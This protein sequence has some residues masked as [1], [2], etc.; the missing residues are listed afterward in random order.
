[1]LQ[2]TTHKLNELNGTHIK[3]CKVLRLY[4]LSE[5][6]VDPESVTNN[7]PTLSQLAE[8]METTPKSLKKWYNMYLHA[9]MRDFNFLEFGNDKIKDHHGVFF[10]PFYAVE[11]ECYQFSEGSERAM[12]EYCQEVAMRV[13]VDAENGEERAMSRTGG[14]NLSQSQIYEEAFLRNFQKNEA[15]ILEL[16]SGLQVSS[17]A[18]RVKKGHKERILCMVVGCEKH[19]QTKCDGCCTI[20]FRLLSSAA[21]KD[22][23]VSLTISIS[24]FV[25]PL[26]RAFNNLVA[27]V[28]SF[29][30]MKK[31]PHIPA[32]A[33]RAMQLPS[34]SSSDTVGERISKADVPDQMPLSLGTLDAGSRVYVEWEGDHRLYKATVKKIYFDRAVPMIRI[35][36]D[37]KKRHILD[38]IPLRMVKSFIRG[39]NPGIHQN[40]AARH[41]PVSQPS[42]SLGNDSIASATSSSK[43]QE[44][45]GAS[46]PKFPDVA[47]IYPGTLPEGK[48]ETKVT[49]PELGSGWHVIVVSRKGGRD[50]RADRYF[51]SPTDQKFRSVKEV[52]RYWEKNPDEFDAIPSAR[53]SKPPPPFENER[54]DEECD[55]ISRVNQLSYST[56]QAPAY[57]QDSIQRDQ[58]LIAMRSI[59]TISPITTEQYGDN[60]QLP[61]INHPDGVGAMG[62]LANAL[63]PS[64][65]CLKPPGGE[66]TA[67]RNGMMSPK[68]VVN[69]YLPTT[70]N[71][72]HFKS[73]F[74]SPSR[75]VQPPLHHQL[76]QSPSMKHFPGM[77]SASAT[78]LQRNRHTT[79]LSGGAEIGSRRP[80]R[81]LKPITRFEEQGGLSSHLAPQSGMQSK[82]ALCHCP[83]CNKGDLS[84]QGIYAHY[85]RAHNGKVLWQKVTFSC[86]FCPSARS[87]R[88]FQ[89]FNE[90]DMHVYASHPGCI[91]QGPHPSKLSGQSN[92]R[93]QN[94]M[95]ISRQ[96]G[97]PKQNDRVLRER[98][99]TPRANDYLWE[100]EP[101]VEAEEPKGPP[102]WT[103][104]EY[105]QLLPD[106][107]KEYPR[108]ISRV[109]EMID[110]HCQKQ[111]DVVGVAREQRIK[112]CKNE[113]DQEIKALDEE[114]LSYQRG[115]RERS[116]MADKERIEKHKF[117]ERLEQQTM[118]YQ[119]ENRNRRRNQE[120]VE[121][122]KLCS[123]PIRFSKETSRQSSREGNACTDEQ[124]QFCQKDKGYLH[125]LL[126]DS[127]ISEFEM[128]APATESP[129]FQQSTKLLNPSFRIID[130][131]YF[132][133]DE[134]ADDGGKDDAANEANIGSKRVNKSRRDAS[135][136]KRL[137]A[138]EERLWM[139]QNTKHS[140]G[141]IEKY[142]EGMILNAW[143][144][145]RIDNR[146]R[147]G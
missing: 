140:L 129:V 74:T 48:D 23:K 38:T 85:G 82:S 19:A 15:R 45:H 139:L 93:V 50:N 115:L 124:C 69:G 91:I 57:S 46:P 12:E 17:T 13:V 98:K 90:I 88:I 52:Q 9:V 62:A 123:R 47:K 22:Q 92:N 99:A 60:G 130:N 143:G 78:K 110:E 97:T 55:E 70:E 61:S 133:E 54:L 3:H 27:F 122:D 1:M 147:R 53:R 135:T 94:N 141:F 138:E 84:V 26:L 102:T 24:H 119:Y 6:S 77:R 20:H 71:G 42:Q 114:R 11:E 76:Y 64:L 86:P 56:A 7:A 10:D 51:T 21:I 128:D 49:C 112:L 125:H 72:T 79:A 108:D 16:G 34:K 63:P 33:S 144:D 28:Q 58:K 40:E 2:Y 66:T 32:N 37:G 107:R 103:E 89:S 36:Y 113:V 8:Y 87:S 83:D 73:T 75:S 105:V 68:G 44:D 117:A 111:E 146:G 145:K 106:G 95:S 132:S 81:K 14:N 80:K 18:K 109:I 101:L 134:G 35:H 43:E 29:Q 100:D 126:L 39:E 30:P 120:D 131:S 4:N 59:I 104:I 136:A 31:S 65:H 142:N 41:E 118:L 137:K 116:R 121:V 25:F 96:N 67:V 5:L 127:E